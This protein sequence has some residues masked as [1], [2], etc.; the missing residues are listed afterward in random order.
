M[1]QPAP[2]PFNDSPNRTLIGLSI[3]VL[4]SLVAEP[5][6]GL[7]DTAFI[8]RLGAVPLAALGVGTLTLSS[9]FWIYNFLGVGSQTE[10]ARSMGKRE[11]R[12]SQALASTAIALAVVLAVATMALG[13]PLAG[14][15]SRLMGA[16][17]ELEAPT[18]LY[19]QIRLLGAPAVLVTIAAFGVLR[20]FQDMTTPLRVAI[21]LN[22]AN[23]VLDPILIFGWGPIPPLEIAGAAL[24]TVIAQ[25][26]GATWVVLAVAARIGGFVRPERSMISLLFSIAGDLFVR[27]GLLTLF[28]L[29]TTRAATLMGPNGGA[30][31]HAIR[32]VWM[33]TALFLDAFAVSGQSLIGFFSGA[34]DTPTARR[35]AAYVCGWSL[36][37][38]VTLGAVML[39]TTGLVAD[40]FVPPTAQPLFY[41]AWWL[42]AAAQPLNA[43][44]FGTDGI[45]WGTG[46]FRFLRNAMIVST[47]VGSAL[48]LLVDAGS[49][50]ALFWIW[51]IT[52]IWI[53]V[54]AG[55][56]VVRIWPGIGDAP[57]APVATSESQ[58]VNTREF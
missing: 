9:V 57:L 34:D 47:G 15:A 22:A 49:A 27:T 50:D 16:T 51:I 36:G 31:H 44:S 6:T 56:G 28:L 4:L 52:A 13:W 2:H 41:S 3:P 45:H 53:T 43:L 29:F 12:R 32:Q 33:F 25:W 5:V 11:E 48:L 39:A 42:A 20:G 26:I 38:G 19:I 21:G 14:I 8:A 30:A 40:V 54:R 23:I 1:T 10:T 58:Y 55:F 7:V 35:V 17:G 24:A 37:T 18:V 46:D